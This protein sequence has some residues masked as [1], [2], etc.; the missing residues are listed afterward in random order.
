MCAP[1]SI[2]VRAT[3]AAA[4][5]DL[6]QQLIDM[7][8]PGD[9]QPNDEM[10]QLLEQLKEAVGE[11]TPKASHELK[12]CWCKM[13]SSPGPAADPEDVCAAVRSTSNTLT[14]C[15]WV[16]ADISGPAGRPL[17]GAVE[18]DVPAGPGQADDA[19]DA[20]LQAI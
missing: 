6:K 7:T 5:E 2:C 1:Q 12:A 8:A 9:V 20:D 11:A 10:K 13:E 16:P 19:R 3:A 14:A 17:L 18:H 4:V 15:G